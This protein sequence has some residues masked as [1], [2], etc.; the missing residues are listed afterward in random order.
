MRLRMYQLPSRRSEV[1]WLSAV[2]GLGLGHCHVRRV[3]Q[4]AVTIAAV[5]QGCRDVIVWSAHSDRA[6]IVE[7]LV[8]VCVDV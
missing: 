8:V 2:G 1:L 5:A 7:A 4:G 6:D 3:E